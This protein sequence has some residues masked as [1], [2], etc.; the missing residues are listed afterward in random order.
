VL[1]DYLHSVYISSSLP[2]I[3]LRNFHSRSISI[4]TVRVRHFTSVHIFTITFLEK[5]TYLLTYLLTYFMVHDILR[6]EEQA[7]S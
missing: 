1:Y 6:I 4:P 5:P 3:L 2:D 7:A